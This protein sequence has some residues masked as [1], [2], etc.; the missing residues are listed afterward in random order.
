MHIGDSASCA[1]RA[2]SKQG[3]FLYLSNLYVLHCLPYCCIIA[4]DSCV[5]KQCASQ[6]HGCH[7]YIVARFGIDLT[8]WYH[9]AWLGTI[10]E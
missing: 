10:E 1:M 4:I 8:G 7:I 2:Q 9:L 5:R 3:L 6:L